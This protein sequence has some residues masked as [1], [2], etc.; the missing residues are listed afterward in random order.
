M[1]SV[2]PIIKIIGHTIEMTPAQ[3]AEIRSGSAYGYCNDSLLREN[4]C[5]S[6]SAISRAEKE[7]VKKLDVVSE[8]LEGRENKAN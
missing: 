5:L 2:Q 6:G 7:R 1:K 3:A 8:F 4:G